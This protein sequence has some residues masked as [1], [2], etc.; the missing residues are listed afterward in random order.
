MDPPAEI[1][2][3][4]ED[5]VAHD[6]ASRFIKELIGEHLGAVMERVSVQIPTPAHLE[7]LNAEARSLC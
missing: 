4:N 3:S 5:E 1:D 2:E 7:H 6:D